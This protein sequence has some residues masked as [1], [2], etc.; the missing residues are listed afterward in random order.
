MSKIII[1]IIFIENKN[2]EF[3]LKEKAKPLRTPTGI[4]GLDVMVGGGLP[5]GRIVL[6]CGGPGTG[7][8]TIAMQ[9]IINGVYKYGENGLYVSFDES[10][11]KIFEEAKYYGWD[12]KTP[13]QEGKIS[14][15][16]LSTQ[17]KSKKLSI[18]KLVN[19]IKDS[20]SKVKAERI[21]VDPLT[22][23]T[24]FFPD[25]IER[26]NAILMLFDALT[27]TKATSIVTD[28]IREDSERAILLEEYLADGVIILRS[29]QV[30]Q[31]RVRTIEIEKMR[32]TQIDDQIRPY[33]IDEDGV[34]VI[35]EKDIFSFAAEFLTR[36]RI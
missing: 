21:S 27:E 35:S 16:D 9:Y 7:K 3:M 23:L 28:E 15:L 36:R 22:A 30:E 13:Y 34:K 25:I 10:M 20:A 17:V 26:R 32:G 4:D 8:T 31:G 5:K 29:S 2:G 1:K 12:F 24:L 19:M 6:I 11:E 33:V 14:F 18:D